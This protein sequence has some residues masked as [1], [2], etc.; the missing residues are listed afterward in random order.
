MTHKQK[1]FITLLL[2]AFFVLEIIFGVAY[3]SLMSILGYRWRSL[4]YDAQFYTDHPALLS[5]IILFECFVLSWLF[6]INIHRKTENKALKQALTVMIALLDVF[7]LYLLTM[8]YLV[9]Q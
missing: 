3:N 5:L 9:S 1:N 2:V 4:Y 8:H 6:Y 7:L